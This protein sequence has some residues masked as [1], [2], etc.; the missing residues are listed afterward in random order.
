MCLL[1]SI[2]TLV[3]V[4][5]RLSIEESSYLDPSNPF[6]ELFKVE[7]NG[8]IPA[9][10]VIADCP[11]AN[12]DIPGKLHVGNN[13]M[14]AGIKI[15][16]YL[17]HGD[18]VTLF[19]SELMSHAIYERERGAVASGATLTIGVGYALWHLDYKLLRQSQTFT[20]R[21]IVGSDGSQHWMFVQ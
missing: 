10:N 8:Y 5:P 2:G 6:T 18:K 9:V 14:G 7:N 4:W 13:F 19:C 1:A 17:A 11:S 12:F 20:F 3:E 16:Y 21:S 15:A